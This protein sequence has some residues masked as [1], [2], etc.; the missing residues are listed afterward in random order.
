MTSRAVL[1]R[2]LC[3][4]V[5]GSLAVAACASPPG[6]ATSTGQNASADPTVAAEES[7]AGTVEPSSPSAVTTSTTGGS[8]TTST[9]G[10][11]TTTDKGSTPTTPP[12][13]AATTT[14]SATTTPPTVPPIATT[15]T[16][17]PKTVTVSII[18]FGYSGFG[19]DPNP[20]TINVGDTIRWINN[21]GVNHTTT[22][23]N[24]DSGT[25]APGDSH[26]ETF[27]SPGTFNYFCSIHG[28][29]S[30]SATVVVSP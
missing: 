23:G 15:T 24:W 16:Q 18:S 27:D 12:K 5:A 25:L 20:I 6:S 2:W 30:M 13:S 3:A 17:A 14:S 8:T 22:S 1:L 11:P 4:A 9:L 29:A 21:D 28:A 10:A 19:Y 7:A 26:P